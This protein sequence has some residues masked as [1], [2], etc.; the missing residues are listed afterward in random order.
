MVRFS[1][2]SGATSA[3]VPIAAILSSD[4]MEIFL[5]LR[6]IN[7]QHSLKATPTPASSLNG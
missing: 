5:P 4:S 1:P 6:L 7:S 2:T 3:T